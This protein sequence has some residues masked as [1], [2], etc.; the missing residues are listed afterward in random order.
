MFNGRFTHSMPCPCRAHAAP[1][2]RPCRSLPCRVAKGLELSLP[3]DL[4]SATVSDSLLSCHVHVMLRP[5][6]SS[7]GQST[8]RP[9]LDGRAVLWP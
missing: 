8:G 9:S 2:P 7:Q 6:R 5:C 3:F 4:Q 1:M